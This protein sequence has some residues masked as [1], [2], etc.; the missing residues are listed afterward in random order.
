MWNIVC[1]GK[2][3]ALSEMSRQVYSQELCR[4]YNW[5]A[6]DCSSD[7]QAGRA[8]ADAAQKKSEEELVPVPKLR[9][10]CVYNYKNGEQDVYSFPKE[11]STPYS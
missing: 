11:A 3:F 1:L 7:Y 6:L 8:K 10:K 9:F 2:S 4:C 5:I